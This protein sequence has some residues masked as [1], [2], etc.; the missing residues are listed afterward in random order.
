MKILDDVYSGTD[1]HPSPTPLVTLDI[2]AAFDTV[3]STYLRI[4]S[5]WSSTGVA[6]VLPRKQVTVCS[7]GVS[8]GPRVHEAILLIVVWMSRNLERYDLG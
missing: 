3:E 8:A 4:R 5:V 1:C 6:S 7:S 2:S